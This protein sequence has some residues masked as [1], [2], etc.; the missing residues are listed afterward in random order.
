MVNEKVSVENAFSKIGGIFFDLDG[1]LHIGDEQIPG[2]AEALIHVKSKGIFCRFLTN[3]TTKSLVSLHK[4]VVNLGLPIEKNEL[5]SAPQAAIH[6]LR[7]KERPSCH[8]VLADDTKADFAEFP[9]T[10]KNPEYVILGDIGISW[11]YTLLN[12]IF[13]MLIEGSILIALHK[14][15]YWQ[16]EDG[17]RLDI[18]VFV[19]GLEY[20]TGREAIIMGKPS[21]AFYHMAMES[22]GLDPETVVMIGD[23]IESDVGGAQRAGIRGAL[24]KTGKYR[25]ELVA[26]SSVHPDAVISS[27]AELVNLL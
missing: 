10:D 20:V 16:T 27:V 5:F 4:K 19:A 6:Y 2:A 21:P 22:T 23:D 24:V 17:L 25:E 18:G 12:S 14:G 11:D 13:R 1:V 8:L 15:R 7:R 3:T 9:R 26:R